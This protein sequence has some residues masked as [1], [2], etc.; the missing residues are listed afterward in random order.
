MRKW[1]S[2]SNLTVDFWAARGDTV[3]DVGR[4]APFSGQQLAQNARSQCIRLELSLAAARH[5]D[6]ADAARCCFGMF[7]KLSQSSVAPLGRH[8]KCSGMHGLPHPSKCQKRG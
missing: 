8:A 6:G 4:S 5:T 3:Q 2:P 7:F 1:M